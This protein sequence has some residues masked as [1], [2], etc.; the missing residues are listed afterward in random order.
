MLVHPAIG[1]AG[2]YYHRFAQTLV[3]RNGWIVVVQEMRGQ[4]TSSVRASRASNWGYWT[5]I[6]Q[7]FDT[8]LAIVESKWPDN[9]IFVAGHSASGAL[10]ALWL[11]KKTFEKES[12]STIKG[13]IVFTGGDANYLSHP[14][15][16]T[17]LLARISQ[18]VI[19]TLGWWP[20]TKM[21]FGGDAEAKD[22]MLDWGYNILYGGWNDMLNCTVPKITSELKNVHKP[23]LYVSIE[24]DLFLPTVCSE[25]L[26]KHYG[27]EKVTHIKLRHKDIP[28]LR[29]TP[30]EQIH[31]KIMRSDEISP[32][33][34]SWVAKVLQYPDSPILPVSAKL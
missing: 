12:L 33:V 7:D 32:I 26:A 25:L 8:H 4:G 15:K 3:Q 1:V 29:D 5:I 31:F 10:W 9:P 13:H 34:E 17:Y 22:F 27:S 2:Q 16:N 18:V 14:S 28:S 11:A 21:G 23:A 19:Y 24:E 6:T 30:I 20:G